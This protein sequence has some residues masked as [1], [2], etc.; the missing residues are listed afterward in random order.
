M[1]TKKYLRVIICFLLVLLSATYLKSKSVYSLWLRYDFNSIP[2][3]SKLHKSPNPE[4]ISKKS[5]EPFSFTRKE[6]LSGIK[7][8][9][10]KK[11]QIYK[12]AICN[13]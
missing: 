4:F 6:L 13:F 7:G 9:F 5:S 8:L 11:S 3:L 2:L 12:T 10:V 1:S